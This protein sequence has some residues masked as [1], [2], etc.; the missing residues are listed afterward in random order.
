[1]FWGTPGVLVTPA[2]AAHYAK[3]FPQLRSVDIGPALHYVQ[4]DHP[5]LIGST[6]AAWM[7]EQ[8]ASVQSV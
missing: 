2:L 1:M 6:I 7:G 8:Q 5:H 4:E 3:T